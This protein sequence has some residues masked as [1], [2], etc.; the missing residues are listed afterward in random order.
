MHLKH[1]FAPLLLA[2]IV[3]A[4]PANIENRES[5]SAVRLV[6][7]AGTTESGLGLVG[8]PLAKEFASVIPGTTSYAIPYDTSTE[9]VASVAEGA[10]MTEQYLAAQSAR[11]PDQRFVLSGYSKGAMVMHKTNLSSDLK[12][13]V[14]AVLVFGDPH[15]KVGKDNT[16]PINLPSVNSSPRS[17]HSSTQNVASF[18]NSGDEFCDTAS[19]RFGPHLAYSSDGSIETAVNFAK[20]RA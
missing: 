12:S 9:Y 1:L 8:T 5:C 4:A 7:A 11:C 18:C 20:E 13:K 10:R 6:H 17:G 3:S 19:A 14:F 16:W 15:R 2:G